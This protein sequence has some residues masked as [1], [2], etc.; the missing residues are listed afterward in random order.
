MDVKGAGMQAKLAENLRGRATT[1]TIEQTAAPSSIMPRLGGVAAGM[2]G[3]S[4]ASGIANA[5]AAQEADP[6]MS[7]LEAFARMGG[8]YE[9]AVEV[10]ILPP[11]PGLY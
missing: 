7:S 3:L 10:G 5:Y 4:M 8:I 1:I 6:S 2:G 11:P 9:A